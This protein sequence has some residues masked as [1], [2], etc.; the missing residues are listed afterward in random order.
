MSYFLLFKNIHICLCLPCQHF[1]F[2]ICDDWHPRYLNVFYRLKKKDLCTHPLVRINHKLESAP[3]W[4]C[5]FSLFPS[6]GS[7]KQSVWP[8]ESFTHL[9]HAATWSR[10]RS[11]SHNLVTGSLFMQRTT[12]IWWFGTL[13]KVEILQNVNK[14]C[15]K[16]LHPTADSKATI[17]FLPFSWSTVGNI[18]LKHWGRQR[19]FQFINIYFTQNNIWWGSTWQVVTKP[20]GLSRHVSYLFLF[21]SW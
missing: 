19:K 20:F 18:L 7:Y 6:H 12:R 10:P 16:K 21:Y 14:C 15:Q 11:M 3:C 1:F 4:L 8:A 17:S 9:P 13:W 2:C 5:R